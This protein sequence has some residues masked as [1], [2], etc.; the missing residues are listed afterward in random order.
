MS[1]CVTGL[2]LG[3]IDPGSQGGVTGL[4]LGLID[5]GSQGGVTGLQ[6]GL[7]DPGSQGGVTG[8]QL[9]LID[10]GSQGGVTGLQLGLIDPGWHG[11]SIGRLP[12]PLFR[13]SAP[14]IAICYVGSMSSIV[15]LNTWQ[16]IRIK[17]IPFTFTVVESSSALPF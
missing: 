13:Y 4:Q 9:G 16:M 8:L 7:I 14:L 6:L 11:G 3:L 17:L 15:S 1:G 2:Q 12:L 10:P 5:P